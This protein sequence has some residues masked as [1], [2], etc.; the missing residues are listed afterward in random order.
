[1]TATITPAT[2]R[3]EWLRW[4]GGGV[5]AS[6]VAA[7]LGLSPWASPWSVWAEKVGLLTS[8]DNP[9]EAMEFGKWAELAIGPWFTERTG[10][11]VAAQQGWREHPEHRYHRATIDGEVHDAYTTDA[12]DNIGATDLHRPP[13]GGLEIKTTGPGRKWDEIPAHYQSQAQ[14]QMHVCTWERVWF[15]VL[16]GRRLDTDHIL[17]RDQADIDFMVERVDAF[18]HDHVLTGIPPEVD[19]S[20]ATAAAMA[21]VWPQHD[22]GRKVSL[23]EIEHVI[24][25][26]VDAKAAKK[27]AEEDEKAAA[28]VLKEALEDA[29]VGT[30][31]GAKAVSWKT[32]TRRAVDVAALKAT[33]P[34]IAKACTTETSVRVLRA[35]AHNPQ[36][37]P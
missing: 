29:E 28:A 24:G 15:A 22:P 11:Y 23:D 5:G 31:G 2:G 21:Q 13:L 25:I 30:V 33:H 27:I 19:G 10:L 14:W 18:W 4:R 34:D 7:I 16:M 32:Q 1:M 8:D 36:E 3:A 9:S 37:K 17:E 26:W 6:D 20:D 35:H 12:L